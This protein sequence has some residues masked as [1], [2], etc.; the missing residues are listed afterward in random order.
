MK[1][2][3][4]LALAAAT[5]CSLVLASCSQEDNLANNNVQTITISFENQK[6]N[7]DGYWIGEAKGASYSYSDD[8]GGTTTTYTDNAY[9]EGGVTLPV[10]YNL[11]EASYGTSDFWSG[12]AISSRTATGFDMT[13]MTPDQYNN[14]TGKAHT[15]KNFA[16]VQTYGETIKVAEG[17]GAVVKSLYYTTSSYTANSILNGDSYSGAKFD[18]TDWFT[19]TVTGTHADGTTATVDI[20]IARDG[21]YVTDWQ[22]ADLS[23]LG[24]VVELGFSFSGSRS[25]AYGVLTPAYLCI[26]DVTIE[27]ER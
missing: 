20:E 1:T 16:I 25:N 11:Y 2:N 19:C 6:L 13:T 4:I 3:K 17:D 14:V 15:G 10:T 24:K 27:I 9:T 21:Q 7:A 26:D 5:A 23:K 8:W 22:L 18:A 12:F